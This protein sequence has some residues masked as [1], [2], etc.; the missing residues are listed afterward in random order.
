MIKKEDYTIYYIWLSE[1]VGRSFSAYKEL[2]SLFGNVFDIYR[3]DADDFTHL[4]AKTMKHVERLCDKNISKAVATADY[5]T[6]HDIHI[7]TYES[8]NY[9]SLLRDIESPPLVLYVRGK[10]PDFDGRLCVATVG[11]RKMT[12]YGKGIAYNFGYSLSKNGAVV[13]SGMALGCDSVSMC[14]ALDAG[15]SIIGVLGCGVDIAYP[16][17]HAYFMRHI[18]RAGALISEY[19][20]G[21]KAEPY[22]FPER[23]RI[24]T[25]LSR[26]LIVIEAD[27]K[28]GA[29]ISAK[30]AQ[31]QGRAV[32]A[33]PGK[34]GEKASEGTVSLIS[35]G[36][37]IVTDAKDVLREYTLLYRGKIDLRTYENI[38]SENIDVRLSARGIKSGKSTDKTVKPKAED[39]KHA[40][41][42]ERRERPLAS[43]VKLKEKRREIPTS[44]TLDKTDT[45][46]LS[47]ELRAIYDKLPK[48]EMFSADDVAAYGITA[49]DFMSGITMLEIYGL[50]TSYP[51][52]RYLL[53]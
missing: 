52:G 50:A 40:E 22:H 34:L 28:S 25:G 53:K 30:H 37:K 9:P 24:I 17:E 21:T 38:S 8:D 49:K 6:G 7:L 5:C 27:I 20:P 23:N 39:K 48:N 3:A 45:S 4:S 33:V 29:M 26:A 13:V 46:K 47:D 35:D 44:D 16:A 11:T 42:P 31:A 32:Y 10:M 14:G 12:E 51:G 15:G 36:A 41:K 1:A 2:I 43:F 18:E 19:P